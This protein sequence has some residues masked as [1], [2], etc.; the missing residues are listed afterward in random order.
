MVGW[1]LK[2]FAQTKKLLKQLGSGAAMPKIPGL[3]GLP[4]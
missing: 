4:R 2:K 1:L 3:P